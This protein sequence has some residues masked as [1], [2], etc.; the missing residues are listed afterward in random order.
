[1]KKLFAIIVLAIC[2]VFVTSCTIGTPGI[3]SIQNVIEDFLCEVDFNNVTSDLE[4]ANKI[5]KK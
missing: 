5:F 4:F 1:M 3:A 2:A